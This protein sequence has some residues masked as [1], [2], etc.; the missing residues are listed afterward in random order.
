MNSADLRARLPRA[1]ELGKVGVL[2]GGDSAEREVSLMSGIGV[3]EALTAMGVEAQLFDTGCQSLADLAAA[4]FDRVFIA[5]H[6]RYGEDG[7][8]QG[9]LEYLRIPYTGS[10]VMGSALAM[11]KCMTKRIW[12]HAGLPTPAWKAVR[13][14][15]ELREAWQ[16]IGAPMIVKPSTE[17]STVGLSK[18]HQASELEPA[19]AAA[20]A[21]GPVL[22]EECIDGRELTVALLESEGE[23]MALPPI[24]IIAP[25]GNYDY[26]NKY[27]GD[28]TRYECPAC[29]PAE[30][31]GQL[32][33]LAKRAFLASGCRGWARVDVM[34]RSHDQTPWLLEINTSPGMTGHSLVP[35]AARA[36]G[37]SYGELCMHLL[38]QA[39]LYRGA[40]GGQG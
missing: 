34:L 23:V 26:Q 36:V 39:Q 20:A 24:E 32:E 30:Q 7:C 33:D 2:Y 6:G 19:W 13:S 27:F 5:L 15:T 25:D 28:A 37:L 16:Q 38:A 35:M 10:P 31:L 29:L 1:L 18:V 40:T 14:L 21:C 22:A 9:A 3:H 12:Q 17:G 8:L 4:R 11:D